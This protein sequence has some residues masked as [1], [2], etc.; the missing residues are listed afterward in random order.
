MV[1]SKQFFQD[2]GMSSYR[3]GG[4]LGFVAFALAAAGHLP[5]PQRVRQQK[6]KD[7]DDSDE[8]EAERNRQHLKRRQ[9]RRNKR[10]TR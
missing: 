4:V 9:E 8:N 5:Q 7:W 6:P 3:L 1:V 10:Q 2:N